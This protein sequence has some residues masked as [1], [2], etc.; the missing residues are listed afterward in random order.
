MLDDCMTNQHREGHARAQIIADAPHC[1][2]CQ[3]FWAGG[4]LNTLPLP[5]HGRFRSN[6]RILLRSV[7][8]KPGFLV[9]CPA[10]A[11]VRQRPAVPTPNA[12]EGFSW[13]PA[14]RDRLGDSVGW[15]TNA[16]IHRE[17]SCE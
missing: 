8:V 10:F 14:N 3:R 9:K 5:D 6:R 13:R 11:S 1:R 2:G 7:A 15:E 17:T 12:R 4:R 16:S